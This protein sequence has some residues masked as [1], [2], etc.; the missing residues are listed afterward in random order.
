MIKPMCRLRKALYG[1]PE[2]GG[3]WEKHLEAAIKGMGG[4]PVENHPSSYWFEGS[5]LLLTVYVDD[6]LLSGPTENHEGFWYQLRYGKNPIKLEDPE[7]LS[8][9]LGR[10]HVPV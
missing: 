2:S 3:H 1:H 8:R 10:E 7:K 5:K 6:L 4:E 9:F